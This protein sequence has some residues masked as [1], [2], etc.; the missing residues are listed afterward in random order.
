MNILKK[1]IDYEG[2]EEELEEALKEDTL[3][4]LRN[5]AK[6]RA[7]EQRVPTYE[8]FRQMAS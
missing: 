3:Y 1:P 2:L 8:H 6:L 4:E 5:S 7:V